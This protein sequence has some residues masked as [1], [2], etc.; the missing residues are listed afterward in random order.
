MKKKTPSPPAILKKLG[1]QADNPGVFDGQWSGSG[2]VLKSVSPIDG[3][4]LASVRTATAADYER[5]VERA[6]VAFTAWQSVPAPKR[7][8]IIRQLGNALRDAKSLLG[9]L[10]TLESGKILAEGEGEVQEM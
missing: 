6:S 5:T 9:R 4:V 3:K 1:L 2:P 10:V 8:E 7:G